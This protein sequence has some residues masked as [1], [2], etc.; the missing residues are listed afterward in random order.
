MRVPARGVVLALVALLVAGC[1][2]V[3]APATEVPIDQLPAGVTV[4]TPPEQLRITAINQ[5][6]IPVSLVVNGRA[7]PFAPGES[8]ELG[9][10][11]LGPLPWDIAFTTATGRPLLRD[12]LRPGIVTRTN[13]GGGQSS[14]TGFLSRADL[15]CGQL[16]VTTNVASFGPAPGPGEPGDCD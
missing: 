14:M 15:S 9:A 4:V 6:T 3:P 5:T 1:S 16:F 13:L 11:D 7:R 10:A 8:A 12:T 2:L